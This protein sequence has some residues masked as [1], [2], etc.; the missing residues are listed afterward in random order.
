MHAQT[1]F[2]ILIKAVVPLYLNVI[3]LANKYGVVLFL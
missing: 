3:M 1:I 2:D